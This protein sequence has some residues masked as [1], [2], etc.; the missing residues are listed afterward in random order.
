MAYVL[1][2]TRPALLLTMLLAS[3]TA[4][5]APCRRVGP[6]AYVGKYAPDAW[7]TEG[8]VAV[9]QRQGMLTWA[10]PL[11]MPPR[12]L[13]QVGKDT[14][15]IEDRTERQV[16]FERN[17]SGCVVAMSMTN[18]PFQGKL[19]RQSDSR[20]LP[21]EELLLGRA[22]AAFPLL[23]AQAGGDPDKLVGLGQRM[24]TVPKAV[25]PAKL[26]AVQIT[27]HFAASAPAWMLL[28][29]A[30][31]ALAE[32]TAA[33]AS[34]RRSFDLDGNQEARRALEMLHLR[35]P[36]AELPSLPFPLA[37]VFPQPTPQ[38]ITAVR[39]SWRARDLKPKDVRV[40]F[41]SEETIRSTRFR[42][43]VVEH[44]VAGAAEIGVILV[45]QH[46]SRRKMPVIVEAKGVSWNFFPLRIP[47]GLNLADILGEDIGRYVI[48][49][50]GF[51]GEKVQVAGKSFTSNSPPESW[52]GAADDLIAFLN[53]ALESTPEADSERICVFGR[54]RGGTVALLAGERDPRIGCVVAWA[55]PTDWFRLMAPAGWTQQQIAEDALRYR[56]KMNER[57]G[58][59]VYNFL[60]PRPGHEENLDSVRL[61]MIASS[62]LYFADSLPE[63]QV[64]Y[65][66]E[67]SIVPERN[68]RK[69]VSRA[70]PKLKAFFYPNAGHDQDLFDAPAN[71][72]RFLAGH[73]RR[74]A[75]ASRHK[76]PA[77][78]DV[79]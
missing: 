42:L 34:F 7:N 46:A 29:D 8:F 74:P 75:E 39:H 11:W 28:G 79:K 21:L 45:P 15:Q 26:L 9:Q 23:L 30:Q 62:P 19:T 78:S 69:L 22:T 41:E 13:V 32:Q 35:E 37:D 61:R 25:R 70:S 64:H 66:V 63:A 1:K 24:L 40:L 47:D 12:K 4:L 56:A 48:V 68:G 16:R 54:S 60:R 52:D 5:A 57:G 10:P 77:H 31:M 18:L 6:A 17:A 38:E 59:F 36:A 51:R 2:T 33:V 27:Q 72:R 44:V 14:F 58:Q 76:K 50:P 53:V 65:G 67:D 55:A 20:L 49:A 43:R 3:L 71:T 73:L